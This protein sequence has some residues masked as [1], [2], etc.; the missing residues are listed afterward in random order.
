MTLTT[1][2]SFYDT[3]GVPKDA[4]PEDIKKAYRAKA[5]EHHPDRG[6]STADFQ[7]IQMAYDTL[8]DP[9]KRAQY[10]AYGEQQ[11]GQ[12]TPEMAAR[13]VIAQLI[14]Q[15]IERQELDLTHANLMAMVEQAIKHRRS[16]VVSD[17]KSLR[18][19]LKRYRIANKRLKTT[20][21]IARK[22]I[23]EK[24]VTIARNVKAARGVRELADTVCRLLPEYTYEFEPPKPVVRSPFA[25]FPVHD[26]YPMQFFTDAST[27]S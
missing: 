17:L 5:M 7:R 22:A 14:T 18:V 3:L 9:D 4:S 15:L 10:D 25:G 24:R 19:A 16:S 2:T 8:S 20:D 23:Y 1:H 27:T 21:P 13:D 11:P 12:E 26:G 6:G